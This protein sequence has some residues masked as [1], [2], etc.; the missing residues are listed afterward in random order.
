MPAIIH[1]RAA[2]NGTATGPLPDVAFSGNLQLENFETYVR[3]AS[4][5]PFH[6]DALNC[7]VQLSSR[8]ILLRNATAHSGNGTLRLDGSAGLVGWRTTP[9]SPIHFEMDAVNFVASEL[10]R[11]AGYR[12]PTSGALTAKGEI[13][14]TISKPQG[15]ATV[16][17]TNGSVEGYT[18]DFANALVSMRGTQASLRN[19][20]IVRGA[21]RITGTGTYDVAA[22]AFQLS[23]SGTDF[24]LS[25]ISQAQ[26]SRI[27]L[28]GKLD[29]TAQA[30]GSESRPQVQ[31]PHRNRARHCDGMANPGGYPYCPLRGDYPRASLGSDGHD[32]ARCIHELIEIVKVQ[33]DHVL[34]SIVLSQ[35][36][37]LR[38]GSARPV[39]NG[40]LSL[41]RH[42][43][44]G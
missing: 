39:E 37:D 22:R 3:A 16:S 38:A 36:G 29:F 19:G 34:C 24:D 25:E 9:E 4:V 32:T 35:S 44:S 12:R 23:L 1:G 30:S 6:W 27:K 20:E 18:F 40:G 5:E 42:V 31:S 26:R 14:G 7:E 28:S 13:T 17:W 33:W 41:L 10:T 2:F 15:Q 8:S 21:A 43:L 11:I